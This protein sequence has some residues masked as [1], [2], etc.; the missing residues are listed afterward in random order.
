MPLDRHDGFDWLEVLELS[1]LDGTN[2]ILAFGLFGPLP[3][4]L[5]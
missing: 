5:K 1:A 3:S 2:L 4:L